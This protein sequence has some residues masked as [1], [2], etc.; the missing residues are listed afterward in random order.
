MK[1][2]KIPVPI[3]RLK[4]ETDRLAKQSVRSKKQIDQVLLT[5]DGVVEEAEK[6]IASRRKLSC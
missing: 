4:R 2:S 1:D 3:Q 5:A 6:S